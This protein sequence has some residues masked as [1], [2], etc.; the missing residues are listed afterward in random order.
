MH[1]QVE[2]KP[3]QS[4]VYAIEL[5]MAEQFH[6]GRV[7]LNEDISLVVFVSKEGICYSA[8]LPREAERG[9]KVFTLSFITIP[10]YRP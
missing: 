2:R 8:V 7:A 9:A 3:G 10:E 5:A 1:V 6:A 4:M